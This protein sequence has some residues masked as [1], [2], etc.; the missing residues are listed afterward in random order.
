MFQNL[1]AHRGNID[2]INPELENSPE[3]ISEA[4]SQ[5]F[6]VEIDLRII[7]GEFYLGHDS[8]QYKV[9]ESY[10]FNDNFW[11]H[12]KNFEA[13]SW[14][15]GKNLKFFWH[16]ND[17]FTFTSNG[18]IWTYPKKELS[19]MSIAVMPEWGVHKNW[20]SCYGICTDFP[21]QVRDGILNL[22]SFVEQ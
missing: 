14:L 9:N 20:R 2:G 13:L 12:A 10:L 6:D 16:Q 15:L 7:G 5:G 17:D 19:K 8:P 18:Y 22:D 11:I 21:K 1:I 3:Y 4:I